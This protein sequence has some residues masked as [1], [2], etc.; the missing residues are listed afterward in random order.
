MPQWISRLNVRRKMFVSI[1][2]CGAKAESRSSPRRNSRTQIRHSLNL[3][4]FQSDILSLM[5]KVFL[6]HSPLV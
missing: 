3:L 6:P 2:Y 4:I 5:D 1:L